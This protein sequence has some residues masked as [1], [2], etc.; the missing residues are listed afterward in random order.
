MNN[1]LQIYSK[2]MLQNN[3]PD[4]LRQVVTNKFQEWDALEQAEINKIKQETASKKLEYSNKIS[5][6]Y[7]KLQNDFNLHGTGCVIKGTFDGD[8][9]QE[10]TVQSWMRSNPIEALAISSFMNSMK[11]KGY[12][13]AIHINNVESVW[14]PDHYGMSSTLGYSGGHSV[15]VTYKQ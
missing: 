14:L 5:S 8:C 2:G 6:I 10:P 9:Y 15:T 7:E 13:L 1:C 12:E 3:I 11:D 4:D